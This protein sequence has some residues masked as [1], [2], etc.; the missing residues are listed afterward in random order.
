M[1]KVLMAAA[2]TTLLA[3]TGAN[4]AEKPKL[5][6]AQI[7]DIAYTA[8]TI[9][10]N[11]AKQALEKSHNIDI[12]MF[13]QEMVADHTAVNDKAT[14]LLKKLG[15]M[16]EPNATSKSLS[17]AAKTKL[18]EFARLSGERF[19]RSYINNEVAF[20][21]TVNDALR[22]TLLPEAQNS[23]LKNLLQSGLKLFEMH[24]MH[25]EEIA[26]DF[27]KRNVQANR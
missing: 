7:A 21:K 3:A 6:D 4:S 13:A 5:N 16:P 22:S 11:A 12:R 19:D 25:A 1:L 15:V 14:A 18:N 10:I 27:N 17:D 9:D 26:G 20:H 24:Q 2:V 23:E 8:D